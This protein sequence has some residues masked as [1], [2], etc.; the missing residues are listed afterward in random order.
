MLKVL[1]IDDHEDAADSTARLL[2]LEGFEAQACLGPEQAIRDVA[3]FAPDVCVIDLAMPGMAG[4][5]LAEKLREA[6]GRPLRCIALT[7]SWDIDSQHR[8]NNAGFEAHLVKP[9]DP[10]KLV[11]AVRGA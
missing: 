5:V 6:V 7:G 8:T 1:C 10:A 9:V 4:D 11:A 3:T 2:R